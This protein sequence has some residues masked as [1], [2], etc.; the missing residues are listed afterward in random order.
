MADKLASIELRPA[1]VWDSE[2]CGR[3]IFV[4]GLAPEMSDEDREQLEEDFGIEEG[5]KG[6][7]LCAPEVV[8]CPYCKVEFTTQLFDHGE[9]PYDGD[10]VD[11]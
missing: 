1:F 5:M 4:R 8:E 6:D 11:S 10:W 2:N 7:F 3:E 9:S